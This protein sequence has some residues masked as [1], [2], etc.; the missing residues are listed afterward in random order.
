MEEQAFQAGNTVFFAAAQLA[1]QLGADGPIPAAVEVP[2][3]PPGQLFKMGCVLSRDIEIG[4]CPRDEP[5]LEVSMSQPLAIAKTEVTNL[6]FARYLWWTRGFAWNPLASRSG[7]GVFG[8]PAR[9]VVKL[10]FNEAV[11]YAIWLGKKATSTWRLPTEAEWEYAARV[12]NEG[13]PLTWGKA[14]PK[15]RANC[16]SCGDGNSGKRTAPVA[17]HASSRGLYDMT[18]N[19]SE[20]TDTWYDETQATRALRGGSWNKNIRNLRAANRNDNRNN[21]MGFRLCR[22]SHLVIE[23]VSGVNVVWPD[24]HRL[25]AAGLTCWSVLPTAIRCSHT[26]AG[27]RGA[28]SKAA[29]VDREL[30]SA[31]WKCSLSAST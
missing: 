18:C 24:E 13:G 11:N 15:D 30:M 27:Q 20:W 29:R 14:S 26:T 28:G 7:T 31:P 25:T 10:D 17:S 16:N 21:T 3:L 19:V 5:E 2:P 23:P 6:Q 1:W 22:S 9:P 4:T 8:T 12:S